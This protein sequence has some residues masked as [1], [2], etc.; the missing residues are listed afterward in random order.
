M[1]F[2]EAVRTIG[3]LTELRRIAGAHVIDHR[4]LQDSELREAVLKSRPQFLDKDKVRTNLERA[5]YGDPRTDYRVISRV[6]LV[7]V[8]LDE[9]DFLL[10]VSTL[11][12]E[13]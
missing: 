7:D 2:D 6:I 13:P 1:K 12:K 11:R 8:I 9:Y 10:P 3:T 5:L 4:Q